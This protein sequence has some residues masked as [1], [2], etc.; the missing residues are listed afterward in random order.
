MTTLRRICGPSWSDG[1]NNGRQDCP[2]KAAPKDEKPSATKDIGGKQ[3]RKPGESPSGD[4]EIETVRIDNHDWYRC[5]QKGSPNIEATWGCRDGYFVATIGK[6]DTAKRL[7]ERMKGAAPLVVGPATTGARGTAT[8]S[9]ARIDCRKCWDLV[10]AHSDPADLSQTKTAADLLGFG[11]VTSIEEV[12]GLDGDNFVN[13]AFFALDGN[14]KGLLRLISDQ[15]LTA[16]DLAPIPPRRRL[17]DGL[18]PRFENK[19]LDVFLALAEKTDNQGKAELLKQLAALD[20]S[21]GIDLQHALLGGLGDTWCVYDSWSEGNLFT[22]VVTLR[23]PAAFAKTYAHL[24]KLLEKQFPPPTKGKSDTFGDISA[25][26]FDNFPTRLEKFEFLGHVIYCLNA[27]ALRRR[28][29]WRTGNLSSRFRRRP[30]KRVCLAG[31]RASPLAVI[32][33]LPA[34]WRA[35]TPRQS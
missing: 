15:P 34:C 8:R 9:V 14:P 31:V 2:K 26:D 30:S 11:D 33:K 16:K 6:A 13:K 1:R 24:M 32:P 23:D 19:P 35:A 29:A 12:W 25:L 7:L 18:S 3:I 4:M 20:K 10:L 17:C 27:G 5:R 22:A 28:G 21:L